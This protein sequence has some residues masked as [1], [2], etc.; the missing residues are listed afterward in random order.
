[1]VQKENSKA[2]LVI[3]VE[4]SGLAF[5]DSLNVKYC[6]SPINYLHLTK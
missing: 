2:L 6:Y 1:M 4:G 5:A 3:S